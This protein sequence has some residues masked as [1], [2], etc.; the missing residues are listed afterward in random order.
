MF[1]LIS[2]QLITKPYQDIKQITLK[3][4]HKTFCCSIRILYSEYNRDYVEQEGCEQQ[5]Q[6]IRN[7]NQTRVSIEISIP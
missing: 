3:V 4:I 2:V 7:F 5:R 1:W 6:V